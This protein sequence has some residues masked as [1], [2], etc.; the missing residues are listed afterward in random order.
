MQAINRAIIKVLTWCIILTA[1]LPLGL[2]MTIFGAVKGIF[3]LMGV[4]IGFLVIGFY[5]TPLIWVKYADAHSYKRIVRAIVTEKIYSIE[6]IATHL[7]V[8]NNIVLDKVDTCIR[9]EYLLGYIRNGD[10]IIPNVNINANTTSYKC[11]ACGASFETPVHSQP[12]CP[13]CGTIIK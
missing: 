4:G 10:E 11:S 8:K 12:K 5:G 13:Y 9:R 2:F 3:G 1:L 7:N 6:K